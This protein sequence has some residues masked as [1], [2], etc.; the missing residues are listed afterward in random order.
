MDIIKEF[1][2]MSKYAGIREDLVQAGGGNSSV[3]L[4]KD[5]MLIK[6]SGIQLSDISYNKGY[7]TVN[8]LV[9]TDFF[10]SNS[11]LECEKE[12]I[13][14]CMINGSRPSIEVF[15][16]AITD[17]FTLHIHPIV[18][19]ILTC[20]KNGIHI[21]KTLFPKAL[22]IE[23]DTP[24]IKLAKKYFSAISELKKN[25]TI[26]IVFL[27]NHGLI[28]SGKSEVEVYEKVNQ[29]IRRIEDYLVID[30]AKYHEVTKIY[31]VLKKI[32]NDDFNDIVYLSN[33][34][35][36]INLIK[37]LDEIGSNICF[38]PDCIVYC[39]KK[40]LILDEEFKLEDIKNFIIEFGK[41]II[42][43][44]K[45]NVYIC[46][47][48]IYKARDIESVLSFGLKVLDAN[49]N[50]QIDFLDNQEQN[51]LLN[52]DAEKYRRELNF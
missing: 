37:N 21:L 14:K 8:P 47:A 13:D 12:L 6:S 24:G 19:N 36:V 49:K 31:T 52:W 33:N 20:R 41:P 38:C 11:T 34:V 39:G 18:V 17:V 48:N 10:N 22:F 25:G 35:D 29:V 23:Y 3:K 43:V 2:E 42:I 1:I 46:A 27:K 28:V 44:Y 51:F 9:I 26:D 30:M 4:S 32:Y 5:K 16:H 45:D 15:L 40:I 50:Y 7:S